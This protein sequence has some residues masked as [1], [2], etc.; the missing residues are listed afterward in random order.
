MPKKN[1]SEFH[2]QR[3]KVRNYIVTHSAYPP[4]TQKRHDEITPLCF[5]HGSAYVETVVDLGGRISLGE[6]VDAQC[7]KCAKLTGGGE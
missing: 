4:Y 6:Y 1:L 7:V 2:T 5:V 3:D